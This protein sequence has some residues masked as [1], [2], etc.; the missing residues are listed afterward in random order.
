[1]QLKPNAFKRG[2][3]SGRPQIGLWCSLCSPLGAEILGD[4]GFDWILIDTEHA[5]NDTMDVMRLLQAIQ[6]S[7]TPA[8]VRVAWNDAVLVKRLLDVGVQSI[9][10]PYIQNA[11]EAA[12]AAA[13]LRYPPRGVRGV[14][15]NSR[16]TRF[17]R[18][19]DYAQKADGEMCALIQAETLEAVKHIEA[20]AQIDGVDGI[21]IGPAD[22]SA[23][24]GY[25]GQPRH[26]EV[27]KVIVD[28]IKRIRG[29]GKAAGFLTPNIDDA[30]MIIEAGANFCAVGSDS[31]LLVN[32]TNALVKTFKG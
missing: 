29:A 31:G 28:A 24:M 21:F 20:M 13:A 11:K 3:A 8:V 10:Y 14:A 1:M 9:L 22:L 6:G 5:P 32:A 25:L 2:L 4:A 23:S 15:T 17:G 27:M 30:K 7:P 16:A 12:A 19:P 26:P 18:I